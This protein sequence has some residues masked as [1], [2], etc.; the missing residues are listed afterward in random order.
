MRRQADKQRITT[1]IQIIADAETELVSLTSVQDGTCENAETMMPALYEQT[2]RSLLVT[3]QALRQANAQLEQRILQQ[4][5]ELDRTIEATTSAT[6]QAKEDF[7]AFLSHEL[8]TPL[9]SILGWAQMIENQRNPVLVEKAISVII[10]NAQRQKELLDD[11]LDLSRILHNCIDMQLAEVNLNQL[12]VGCLQALQPLADAHQVKLVLRPSIEE[13]PIFVD[14]KRMRQVVRNLVENALK[15][16][17]AQGT[18][19]VNLQQTPMH[20]IFSVQDTGKGIPF[21]SLQ[22]IFQPFLQIERSM[23]SAG[24]G[25]GLALVKGIVERHSGQVYASSSGPGQGSTFTILLP[26]AKNVREMESKPKRC[27]AT[28]GCHSRKQRA[29]IQ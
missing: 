14:Q 27:P 1:L 13:L 18:V 8:L 10:R 12:V 21:D 16:T 7:L 5:R 23:G 29:G 6:D 2:Q 17:P 22:T 24:L 3:Q 26:L 25:L 28:R 4:L 19:T 15:F 11:L 9:T 20:A